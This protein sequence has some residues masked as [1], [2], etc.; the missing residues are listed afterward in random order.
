MIGWEWRMDTDKTLEQ[1]K[2]LMQEKDELQRQI[3]EIDQ[4]IEALSASLCPPGGCLLPS[5]Q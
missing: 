1:I 4:Q 2:L 5:E 3:H